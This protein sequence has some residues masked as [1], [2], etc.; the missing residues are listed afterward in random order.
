MDIK[1]TEFTASSQKIEITDSDS[2]VKIVEEKVQVNVV[3]SAVSVGPSADDAL[4]EEVFFTEAALM[5]P[6]SEKDSEEEPAADK[7]EDSSDEMLFTE[8]AIF[9]PL[10]EETAEEVVENAAAGV[11]DD[12]AEASTETGSAP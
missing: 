4:P 6:S 1:Q 12:A 3:E 7:E 8:A 10:P 5:E 11:S 9:E 2:S